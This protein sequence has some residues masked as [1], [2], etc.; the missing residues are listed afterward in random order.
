MDS[1]LLAGRSR[2]KQPPP[3][4]HTVLFIPA[5]EVKAH[6]QSILGTA[7]S[8]APPSPSKPMTT[9][10]TGH[11]NEE[12]LTPHQVGAV[13]DRDGLLNIKRGML[14]LAA[15]VSSLPNDLELNPSV[16]DFIEQVVRPINISAQE[17]ENV[18]AAD[19]EEEGENEDVNELPVVVTK[20][21]TRPIS[22]PVDVC[23]NFQIHPS[24]IILT[25]NP[26]ARVRCQV[27]IPTV[28][29][30]VSCSL[31]SKRQYDSQTLTIS[32][33]KNRSASPSHSSLSSQ[34]TPTINGM[35]DII[36]INNINLTGC[37]QTFQLTMFTPN[38]QSSSLLHN[39]PVGQSE[40]KE[41]ISLVLGQAF[42]HLSRSSVFVQERPPCKSVDD[43]VTIEKLKVSGTIINNH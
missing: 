16:L 34:T 26:H 28:S 6:Y 32:Q 23:L 18:S 31:F 8:T 15:I 36:T 40:D 27:A 5:L 13:S 33:S 38:V 3:S 1:P 42:I 43:C 22:F 41:V 17:I 29:F 24:K 7:Y 19:L 25:C 39:Q 12:L 35:D 37:L 2:P 11:I 20:S 9:P 21:D 4:V 14:T 30:V 10:S